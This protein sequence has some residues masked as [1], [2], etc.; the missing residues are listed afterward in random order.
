MG[1]LNYFTQNL[2]VKSPE[3]LKKGYRTFPDR[4]PSIEAKMAFKK[5]P[6]LV[7]STFMNF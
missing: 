2:L 3:A 1:Q 4:T 5:Y 6:S 7:V